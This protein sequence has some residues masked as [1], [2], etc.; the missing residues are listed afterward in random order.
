M[1]DSRSCGFSEPALQDSLDP[2]ET[3]PEHA[4]R[5]IYVFIC[6]LTICIA[7]V[8]DHIVY[9]PVRSFSRA[10]CSLIPTFVPKV[11]IY[12]G[13]YTCDSSI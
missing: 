3:D 1:P 6:L 8:H 10:S 13:H 4:S 9:R 11:F 5:P 12:M 2:A 7:R